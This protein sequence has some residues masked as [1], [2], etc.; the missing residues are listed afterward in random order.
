MSTCIDLKCQPIET[1]R[2]GLIGLGNRGLA[3]LR[4]YMVVPHSRIAALSDL[5]GN[6]LEQAISIL[7]EHNRLEP[8]TFYGEERWRKICESDEVDIVY[9]CTDWASHAEMAT[10][11]MRC[12]KHVALEVP[13]AM[14]VDECWQ[15]VR[16]AEQTQRHCVMLENCCYDT[17]HL[18]TMGMLGAGLLGNIT[19]CE[20]AYIHDLRQRYAADENNGGYHK[21]WMSQA[22]ATHGGNP[23]P[24][25]GLGPVCQI[26]GI[27]RSDHLASLTSITGLN[28]INNTL[29]HTEMG[30]SILIQY[31]VCTP[32]PY[33]RMQT[34]CG[35]KG[36]VQKYPTACVMLDGEEAT[37]GEEATARCES[38]IE[39]DTKAIIH[40][41]QQLGVQNVMNYTMDR[42]LIEALHEGKPL[43]MDVYDAAEW[44]CIT[45]LS[46]ISALN[47]GERVEIPRFC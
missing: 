15:I 31:D 13:A 30:R 27:H 3:T 35:T 29:I 41:G 21:G 32:R 17:F 23:Y 40:E 9:I 33:S 43:D 44:S 22:S 12:G 11:A 28:N 38:Y 8:T 37:L 24:T 14:T 45:E 4:R 25:H 36:F 5:R 47:G 42:R 34:V 19:H 46:Q 39:T 18:G 7:R 2:I 20:G 16:T 6:N 26:L 10:Y 1:V